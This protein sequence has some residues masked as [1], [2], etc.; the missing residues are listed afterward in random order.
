MGWERVNAGGNSI[1]QAI[2][3]ASRLISV[4]SIS[5]RWL[6]QA[7]V[8][9]RSMMKSRQRSQPSTQFKNDKTMDAVREKFGDA[10]VVRGRG[11]GTKLDRQGPSKVE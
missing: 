4:S 1:P 6:V 3:S 11:F 10:A 2:S 8:Y 5:V 7:G 9:P